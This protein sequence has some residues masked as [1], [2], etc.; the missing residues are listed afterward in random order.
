MFQVHTDMSP[1]AIND[2][3]A[4]FHT[5][6]LAIW[7]GVGAKLCVMRSHPSL[8]AIHR[9]FLFL[10]YNIVND[11]RQCKL[12]YMLWHRLCGELLVG[13][14]GTSLQSAATLCDGWDQGQVSVVSLEKAASGTDSVSLGDHVGRLI[15]PS[16][17]RLL[18]HH[19]TSV[20]CHR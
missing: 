20:P 7:Q 5:N 1:E 10:M 14:A 18:R 2:L 3:S 6:F 4:C 13:P 15:C 17:L 12:T 11:T 16:P 19:T 9:D 8:F